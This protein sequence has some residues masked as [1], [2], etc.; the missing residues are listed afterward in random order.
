ME[1]IMN[2]LE[3]KK[4]NQGYSFCRAKEYRSKKKRKGE[5]NKCGS[6]GE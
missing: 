6:K 2:G 1:E 4:N 3:V 5:A